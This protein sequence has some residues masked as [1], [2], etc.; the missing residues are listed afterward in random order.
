MRQLATGNRPTWVIDAL[1]L[2]DSSSRAW[3]GS[4]SHQATD[5]FVPLHIQRL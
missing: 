4:A 2:G 3:I 1:R 5:G